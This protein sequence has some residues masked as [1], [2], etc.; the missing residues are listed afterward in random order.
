MK[1]F[2]WY[3]VNV[4]RLILAAMMGFAAWK[5]VTHWKA[6]CAEKTGHD[7]D[8]A[9]NATAEKLEK[10]AIALEECADGGLG[11][12]LGKGIDELLL[13]TKKTLE[14]AT[15]IINKTLHHKA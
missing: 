1:C 5:I 15:D 3:V 11:E 6:G 8:A 9:I 2:K 13:D 4:C 12:N 7:A 10:A 14:T